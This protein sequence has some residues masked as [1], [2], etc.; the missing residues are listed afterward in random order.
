MIYIAPAP[1]SP[2]SDAQQY[3]PKIVLNLPQPCSGAATNHNANVHAV[4]GREN[5]EFCPITRQAAFLD[6]PAQA[7]TFIFLILSPVPRSRSHTCPGRLKPT[8]FGPET[9]CVLSRWRQAPAF[10]SLI[11]LYAIHPALPCPFTPARNGTWMS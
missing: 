8:P 5:D 3:R 9:R 4:S 11:N 2:N 1:A 6:G 10:V 7:S